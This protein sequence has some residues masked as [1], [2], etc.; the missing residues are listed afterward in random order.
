MVIVKEYI[1]ALFTI[2]LISVTGQGLIFQTEGDL[3]KWK[4]ITSHNIFYKVYF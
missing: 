4:F 2:I 1:F 3:T